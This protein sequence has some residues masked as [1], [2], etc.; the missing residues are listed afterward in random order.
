MTC[1]GKHGL[2]RG[3]SRTGA[4]H[5]KPSP[6]GMVLTCGR[7]SSTRSATAPFSGYRQFARIA[8]HGLTTSAGRFLST[9]TGSNGGRIVPMKKMMNK[10]QIGSIILQHGEPLLLHKKKPGAHFRP[11]LYQ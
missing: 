1:M 5:P 6:V 11:E 8:R 2:N 4:G 3:D 10:P 9:S 7:P